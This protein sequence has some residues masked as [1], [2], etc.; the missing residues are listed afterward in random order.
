MAVSTRFAVSLSRR[1][2]GQEDGANVDWL[3]VTSFGKWFQ[4]I[5]IYIYCS[6]KVG[7]HYEMATCDTTL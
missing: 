6:A 4:Q 3:I 2:D 1:S 5:Y 7:K